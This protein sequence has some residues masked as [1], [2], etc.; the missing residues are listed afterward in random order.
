MLISL[1]LFSNCGE[2]KNEQLMLVD[3]QTIPL[4]KPNTIGTVCLFISPDCPLSHLY[5]SE[6]VKLG[7]RFKSN[8]Q[9]IGLVPGDLYSETEIIHFKDS[10]SFDLPIALDKDLSFTKKWK[11]TTTPECIVL[12]T[13]GEVRYRGAIDNWAIDFANKRIE[14]TAFY[15]LDALNAMLEKKPVKI[16]YQKPV[17]CLIE[18][19]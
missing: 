6:Y 7:N 10:F 8:F 12:D 19:E 14:P 4:F 9:F 18:L 13:F 1:V 2:V 3:G 17:G 16:E 11:A 15:L 5:A